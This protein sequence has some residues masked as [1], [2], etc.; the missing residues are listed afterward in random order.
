MTK[1]I[2]PAVPDICPPTVSVLLALKFSFL[3]SSDSCVILIGIDQV[4]QKCFFVQFL[5]PLSDMVKGISKITPRKC[6][7]DAFPKWSQVRSV[8]FRACAQSF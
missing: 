7:L 6:L 8:V 5:R 3:A 1:N 4:K 2:R